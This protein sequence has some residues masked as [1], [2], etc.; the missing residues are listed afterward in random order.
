M[1]KIH[2]YLFSK[3]DNIGSKSE[4][5][6]YHLQQFDYTELE[7]MKQA[8]LW[9][10][11]PVLHPLIASKV[12]LIGDVR[13]DGIM[14]EQA[15][16]YTPDDLSGT[17]QKLQVALILEDDTLWIDKMPGS[18]N[19][20]QTMALT[21]SVTWPFR[22]IWESQ[23][24]TTQRHD[25]WIEYQ[26]NT[27]WRWSDGQVF[28]D[29]IT[30]VKIPGGSPHKFTEVWPVNTAAITDEG[31]YTAHAVHIASGITVSDTF[32]IKFAH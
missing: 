3:L 19:T 11:D 23:C 9:Q 12:T 28:A 13:P 16:P 29:V 6:A 26:G 31:I 14:Y 22:S 25:F 4:G 15:H 2:G 10:E 17:L 27:L 30:P 5:P 7:V 18:A 21:L 32:K 1:K 20:E 8:N 24:P